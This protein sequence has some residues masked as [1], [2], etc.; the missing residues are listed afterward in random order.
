MNVLKDY[1]ICWRV[2]GWWGSSCPSATAV[3][4]ARELVNPGAKG[5]STARGDVGFEQDRR[6]VVGASSAFSRNNA[7]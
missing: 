1:R 7:I 5:W 3:T 2:T 6:Q 4:S